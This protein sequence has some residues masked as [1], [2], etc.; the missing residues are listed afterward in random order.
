MWISLRSLCKLR[1][2]CTFSQTCLAPAHLFWDS[3][4]GRLQ[5]YLRYGE[6]ALDP[7]SLVWASYKGATFA[8]T[9][10]ILYHV[11]RSA[12]GVM[13]P[14]DV[15]MVGYNKVRWREELFG[16]RC[17]LDAEEKIS[18]FY[19]HTLL[20]PFPFWSNAR[21]CCAFSYFTRL[22]CSLWYF[23]LQHTPRP[24]VLSI[25]ASYSDITSWYNS[26]SASHAWQWSLTPVAINPVLRKRERERERGRITARTQSTNRSS[27]SPSRAYGIRI[28]QY[29]EV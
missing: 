6:G 25:G 29:R 4:S 14:L 5:L 17:S 9:Q 28:Y 22:A 16:V 19:W 27:G 2:T 13:A 11:H 10:E 23:L 8:A 12:A 21:L 7:P 24:L 15:V 18:R 26:T 3:W 1:E 20:F